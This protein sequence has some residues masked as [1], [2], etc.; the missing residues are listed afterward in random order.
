MTKT[1]PQ[2]LHGHPLSSSNTSSPFPGHQHL[3]KAV[4]E[5][6]SSKTPK[7]SSPKSSGPPLPSRRDEHLPHSLR[8]VTEPPISTLIQQITADEREAIFRRSQISARPK[9]PW[10][11]YPSWRL[12]SSLPCLPRKR[13]PK[14]S[15]S[16]K[17]YSLNTCGRP[18]LCRRSFERAR[19]I[20][21]SHL[22]LSHRIP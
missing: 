15:F 8:L 11:S 5:V 9:H 16:G 2:A 18:R 4:Q 20:E 3:L 22:R 13:Y 6:F 17:I 10:P 12:P 14:V 1:Q 19:P 21:R 7:P